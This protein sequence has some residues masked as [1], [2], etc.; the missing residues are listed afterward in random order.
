MKGEPYPSTW[1]ASRKIY[2]E[3][4]NLF[5]DKKITKCKVIHVKDKTIFFLSIS[6]H[7]L[8]KVKSIRQYIQHEENIKLI[9]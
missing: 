5:Q 8:K 3:L 2:N 4:T 9:L 6:K 7:W 1:F